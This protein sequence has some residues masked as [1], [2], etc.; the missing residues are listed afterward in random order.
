MRACSYLLIGGGIGGTLAAIGIMYLLLR[1]RD[2]EAA[3]RDAGENK[4][5][6]EKSDPGKES[7]SQRSAGY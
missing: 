7:P 2:S 3:M 1:P 4:A 6:I 5:G